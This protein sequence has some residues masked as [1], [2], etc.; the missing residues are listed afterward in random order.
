MQR[1]CVGEVLNEPDIFQTRIHNPNRKLESYNDRQ[2]KN[3]Q[4]RISRKT[5]EQLKEGGENNTYG[6]VW[7]NAQKTFRQQLAKG[8]NHVNLLHKTIAKCNAP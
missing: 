8:T 2:S 1:N 4:K 7:K 5:K 3:E 6:N